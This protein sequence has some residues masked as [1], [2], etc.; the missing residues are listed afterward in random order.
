MFG[1]LE[2]SRQ[3][4]KVNEDSKISVKCANCNGYGRNLSPEFLTNQA[5]KVYDEI[6]FDKPKERVFILCNEDFKNEIIKKLMCSSIKK[7]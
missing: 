4:L 6:T 5:L 3:R 7:I 1:L 2:L